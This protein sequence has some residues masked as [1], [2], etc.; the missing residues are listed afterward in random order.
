MTDVQTKPADAPVVT[1]SDLGARIKS[2][3]SSLIGLG[4]RYVEHAI[5][6]GEDL[7]QA[8]VL[9]GHGNFLK[10]VKDNCGFTDKTA[11]RYMKFAKNKTKLMAMEKVKFET[12]SN[13]TLNAAERLIDGTGSGS[14]S[15]GGNPNDAYDK[16]Q[17]RLLKK[18]SSMDPNTAEAAAQK[19]I[20]EL[21]KIVRIKKPEKF[22]L[23]IAA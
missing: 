14:G 11:E 2:G 22:T 9:V 21:A 1:L 10:W 15:G 7:I 5:S 17:E 3:H 20:D 13:L 23:K 18:L 6:I 8:Q 16:V 4:R 19:T 12:I